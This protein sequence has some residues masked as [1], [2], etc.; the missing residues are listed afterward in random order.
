MDL[1]CKYFMP[2]EISISIICRVVFEYSIPPNPRHT[3]FKT[4]A[5]DPFSIESNIKVIFGSLFISI[6]E[7]PCILIYV[8]LKSIF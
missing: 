6:I 4:S 1:S 3:S 7:D 5:S 8:F 2:R